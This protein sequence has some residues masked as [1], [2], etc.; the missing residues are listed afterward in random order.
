MSI[1][2]DIFSYP[3]L[4]RA[5]IVGLLVSL[6][7][8]LLG[9]SLVLRRLSMIG[10]GLSHVGFGALGI[11]ALLSVSPMIVTIPI[12]VISA[13]FL[14]K[15]TEK[16]RS[17][18]GL[19]AL[20]SSSC[21]AIGVIAVSAA[22]VNTDLNAFLFGSILS[23]S[24]SDAYISA[25]LS[26]VTLLI[27]VLFYHQIYVTT[28]DPAFAKATGIKTETYNVLLSLLTA[29]TIVVGM[30]ILGSLLVS[31]L[32]IFPS[33][34][35]MRL[36]KKYFSVTLFSAVESLIA[37]FFGFVISYAFSLPAGA[38]IVAVYVAFYVLACL[39][40]LIKPHKRRR[41]NDFFPN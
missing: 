25:V 8:S 3:F 39:I 9:V 4:L 31:S 19:I 13:F 38:S 15:L 21:L 16:S 18:D 2:V 34:T 10:D 11:A 33:F 14:L 28:F 37:F 41:K 22:G 5:F 20:I 6:A 40:S 1:L 30:R 26:L 12:L 23:V 27:Y 32:I 7:A 29:I 17:G 35:A 36:C 24:K